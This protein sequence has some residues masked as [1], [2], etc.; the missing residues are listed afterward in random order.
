MKIPLRPGPL[1]LA[2]EI[3]GMPITFAKLARDFNAAVRTAPR[4]DGH[5]VVVI[6]G[7]TAGDLTTLPLRTFLAFI[8]YKT[9]GWEQGIN[10]GIEPDDE[11]DLEK[12]LVG[13]AASDGPLT[14]IGWSLGGVY[15]RE[16]GRRRPELVRRVITLGTPIRS[17]DGSDWIVRVLRV[18]NPALRDELTEEGAAKYALPIDMPMTAIWSRK[19]G[20]VMGETCQLRE[21][22]E[23]PLAENIEVDSAHIAMGFNTKV[24]Q[25]IAEV[26]ARPM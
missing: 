13:L 6:P 1:G 9:A 18:L 15:A 8:G 23:G 17:R 4:G 3:I 24:L 20:I 19:D 11:P 14:L 2:A 22:D 5:T 7:F 25:V 12:Y 26:L 21:G 16:A 10:L